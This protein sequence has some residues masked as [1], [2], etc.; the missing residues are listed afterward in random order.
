MCDAH[1][2]LGFR[3]KKPRGTAPVNCEG[4]VITV[5]YCG[6]VPHD[7]LFVCELSELILYDKNSLKSSE[8]G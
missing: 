3:T 7:R 8:K 1:D 6:L 5:Q 4:T 2:G